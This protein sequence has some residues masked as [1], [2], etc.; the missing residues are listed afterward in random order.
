MSEIEGSLVYN[1]KIKNEHQILAPKTV[2]PLGYP[3]TYASQA[4]E[5]TTQC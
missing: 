2:M 1:T 4:T 3:L 5:N